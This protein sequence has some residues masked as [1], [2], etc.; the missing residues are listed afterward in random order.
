LE[1]LSWSSFFPQAGQ[2]QIGLELVKGVK[3]ELNSCRAELETLTA[4]AATRTNKDDG[5]KNEGK[6]F[7]KF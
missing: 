2:Q 3:D 1:S 5:K 4:A 6:P 7:L